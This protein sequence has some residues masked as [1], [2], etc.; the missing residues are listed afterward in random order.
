MN[1]CPNPIALGG[2]QRCH[3][4][5][6]AKQPFFLAAK[7]DEPQIMNGI[8]ITERPGDGQNACA[9]TSV[10]IS[11]WGRSR[12]STRNV[13]RVEMGAH[14]DYVPWRR[15]CSGP[16]SDHVETGTTVDRDGLQTGLELQLRQGGSRQVSRLLIMRTRR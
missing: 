15:T 10:I 13:D 16:A 7:Q 6:A 3:I 2:G 5:P 8:V 14:D 12:W 11:T 4:E 9:A 1:D